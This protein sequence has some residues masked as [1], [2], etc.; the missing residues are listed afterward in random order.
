MSESKT[1]D[2][3]TAR[4]LRARPGGSRHHAYTDGNGSV[5]LVCE[6]RSSGEGVAVNIGALD[7]LR[8]RDGAR[9]V[10]LKHPGTGWDVILPLDELP[11][12]EVREGRGGRYMFVDPDDLGGPPFPPMPEGVEANAT[13]F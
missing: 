12:N 9:F 10:R 3:A 4:H 11:E 13:P 5:C 7:W 6:S 1:F 8:R 2:A